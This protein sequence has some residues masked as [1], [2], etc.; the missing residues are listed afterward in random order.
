MTDHPLEEST[1]IL[2]L[3]PAEREDRDVDATDVREA[4]HDVIQRGDQADKVIEDCTLPDLALA[5]REVGSTNRHPVVF[6]DCAFPE[7]IGAAHADIRVPVRF[8]DCSIAGAELDGARFEY[9]LVLQETTFTDK[10]T[11]FEARFDRDADFTGTTFTAPVSFDEATFADDS[12]FDGATFEQAASFRAASFTGISNELDDNASFD[13]ATFEAGAAFHQATFGFTSFEAVYFEGQTTF[14]E[15]RFDGD[16]VFDGATFREEGDFDEVRF[17]EDASFDDA[18]FAAAA[19]FRGATFE[20]GA[21]SLQDDARFVDT[22]FQAQANFRDTRF[23][24][25]NFERATFHDHAMLEEARFGADADFK[26]TT[27]DGEVDFDEAQ[28]EGDA[29]FSGARF[30]GPAVFRGATFEGQAQHLEKNAVFENVHFASAVDFDNA[31]FTSANFRGTRFGDVTDFSGAEF[32]DDLDFRAEAVGDDAYVDFTD[33]VLKEGVITQPAEHWV[34][35]DLTR[36]SLGD[37]ALEA[38]RKGGDR[39]I[40]D[41]FRFCNTEFNEFDGYEFDFSAHMYYL[42]RNDWNL[43]AFEEPATSH[44]YALEMTPENVETTYLKAKK[45]ASAGGYVKAAGEFRVQRQR[46]ARKK[47]VAI[48]RDAAVEAGA[49]VANASRAVENYFLDL[50]C[51]YGMRLGRILAVFLIAPL[52]PA[53]LYAFGGQAFRTGAGQLSSIGAVATPAGQS[54]L[55]K[56]VYFS[57]ITFLTIGYGGIGPKGALARI[58]AGL[59]V[60]LSVILGGLVLYALI[61]RSEL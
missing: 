8:E 28:F 34:R 43:H 1:T 33:A 23:R 2:E 7:G 30:E 18:V 47:H 55:F 53:A 37:I 52:L 26:A 61:K 38:E 48:A 40:L 46:H 6:R 9:D 42:D 16:A 57:Y 58:L 11:G 41:Y 44:D 49:R 13:G 36:A 50:T 35:Y 22:G 31:S 4:L 39:E 20:G 51:G 17:G 54:V 3:S 15:A 14:Q 19:V 21:R 25:V 29:D 12:S 32:T 24:Y 59:E 60:Y 45:A 5:N 56:N 27:F 10:V